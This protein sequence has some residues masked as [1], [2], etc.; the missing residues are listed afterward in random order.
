MNLEQFQNEFPQWR[1]AASLA[2]LVLL[3]FWESMSPYFHEFRSWKERGVHGFRNVLVGG[4]NAL[5]TVLLFA[6][7][8]KGVADWSAAREIG[9]LHQLPIPGWAGALLA[10]L[11]FDLWTY[12]W[13]RFTHEIPFLWRFH[14]MHHSDPQMD[15]TTANRFHPGEI[16]LSSLLRIPLIIVLGLEFWQIVL[17]ETLLQILV[18][19]QHANVSFPLPVDRVLR[20]VFA[21]PQMHKVHHSKLHPETNSNYGSLFSFWDRLFSSF[22]LRPDPRAIEFGLDQWTEPPHQSVLGMWRTPFRS[23]PTS[24]PTKP[25]RNP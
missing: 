14:R 17:Y 1:G 20:L 13:H 12:W 2:W 19:L 11:L 18:Q 10:V 23:G 9:L 4:V 15:V 6:F 16:I 5:V 8:W 25:P 7:V 22:R 3:L 21:T 24:E